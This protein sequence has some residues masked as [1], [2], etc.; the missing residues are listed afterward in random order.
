MVGIVSN[1]SYKKRQQAYE[2]Y[3]VV[4]AKKQEGRFKKAELQKQ[5]DAALASVAVLQ[6]Q[7]D[8]LNTEI[9]ANQ[10]DVD[11]WAKKWADGSE[12]TESR[13]S[14][15]IENTE[16]VAKLR[17]KKQDIAGKEAFVAE[18]SSFIA[19]ER[20]K[21][22]SQYPELKGLS[23]ETALERLRSAET[24]AKLYISQLQT[25]K[26]SLESFLAEAKLSA[27]QFAAKESP[28]LAGIQKKLN[29]ICSELSEIEAGRIALNEIYPEITGMPYDDAL[30]IL[31]AKAN[32]YKLAF[33]HLQVAK[34]NLES[35]FA[36]AK[37]SAEQ[38]GAEE[39]PEIAAMRG[40]LAQI[41]HELEEL[42][43][44]RKTFDASY[45]EIGGLPYEAAL[46]LLRTK[47][48]EYKVAFSQLQVAIQI[49]AK[50]VSDAKVDAALL[51]AEESPLIADMQAKLDATNSELEQA[52]QSRVQYD[53]V[54]PEIE[55]MT[56]EDAVKCLR[57]KESNYRV[58]NG[59]LQTALHNLQKYLDDTK[60][61]EEQF[62]AEQ[63]PRLAEL[64]AARDEVSEILAQA[65]NDANDVLAA[66]D[67]DTDAAHIIQAIRE[68]E[69]MLNEYKQYA[70]KLKD[71][72]ERQEKKRRQINELQTRLDE[73][74]AILQ[75]RY[76]DAEISARL[77]L[78]RED[79]A[80]AAILKEK[81][82]ENS[83][84]RQNL[85]KQ[86]DAASEAINAFIAQYVHFETESDDVLAGV[87]A[88]AG[89]YTELAAAKAQLEKQR[90]G[91]GQQS[92]APVSQSEGAEEAELREQISTLEARRDALLVEYTQK[93]DFIRQAD[94]SLEK[95]PDI[96][97]E[98]SQLYDQKQRAQNTLFM[99]KRTI[100][101]I[102]RAKGN[103]A[104]RYLGKVERMFNSYLQIWLQND[105]IH[106]ILDI[107]FKI[108]M[109][110]NQK[111]HL[112]EGYSTGYCDLI[113]LCMRLALVDTLFEGEAPFLILD[114]PFVNLD[115]DRLNKSMDLL[116]LI[117]SDK[118]I[119]YFVCHPVR[120][121]ANGLSNIAG[122][123]YAELMQQARKAGSESIPASDMTA[124]GSLEAGRE[125]YHLVPVAHTAL[126]KPANPDYIITT[127]IFDMGIELV[128]DLLARD[129]A[130]ELFFIDEKGHVRTIV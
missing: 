92:D 73:K 110:D 66:L 97:A 23:G 14:E 46:K 83:R 109:E 49:E 98:T 96:L 30:R 16:Q 12:V 71:C 94:K 6:K 74:L 37:L 113:D 10:A 51:K 26:K 38:L 130:Y 60:L 15:I 7:I 20:R 1:N 29:D 32:D 2:A 107:D 58:I 127:S 93:S 8:E 120:S 95:Y 27:D 70:G 3:K 42:K 80:N 128:D 31:R 45:P 52:A 59:Q 81:S 99:L 11:A 41:Q 69:Q 76:E 25:A 62:A 61:T 43:S 101:L 91:A 64:T 86:F 56:I 79:V 67:L 44:N 24:E 117:A 48:G 82:V 33:G 13:I 50:S 126:I 114:D 77:K 75:G 4:A 102:T 119:I 35:F 9:A 21:I 122:K 124:N 121:E 53:R 129:A 55:G 103:L 105:A 28:A 39:S 90:S 57:G 5:L 85:Q 54:F 18:Q 125:K 88:R 84:D 47:A 106:G 72:A 17:K 40:K 63:S 19:E 22:D 118:Q 89:K 123:S 116:Q 87:Y 108:S 68:A 115:E 65:L 104:N 100:Q 111:V 34:K 36:E 112:A 78:V